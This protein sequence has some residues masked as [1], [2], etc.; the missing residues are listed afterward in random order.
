VVYDHGNVILECPDGVTRTLRWDD[1]DVQDGET[2]AS[3]FSD[4]AGE[5]YLKIV[6]G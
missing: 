6:K 1:D 5:W 2:T 4:K 3:N